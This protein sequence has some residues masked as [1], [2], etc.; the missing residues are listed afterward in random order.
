MNSKGLSNSEIWVAS[1]QSVPLKGKNQGQRIRVQESVDWRIQS[2]RHSWKICVEAPWSSFGQRSDGNLELHARSNS[3][4]C[5]QSVVQQLWISFDSVT[6]TEGSKKK[7]TAVASRSRSGSGT[8]G[9]DNFNQIRGGG[10]RR[11]NAMMKEQ[12]LEILSWRGQIWEGKGWGRWIKVKGDSARMREWRLQVEDAVD[13]RRT[14]TKH[15]RRWIIKS[16]AT[17]AMSD[18]VL[19]LEDGNNADWRS[20]NNGKRSRSRGSGTIDKTRSK[21]V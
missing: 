12:R 19:D 15:E 11:D 13:M 21:L 20:W 4:Q 10:G 1:K 17:F 9:S 6:V 2:P 16:M 18:L 14:K 5:N 8:A 3:Q 7:V